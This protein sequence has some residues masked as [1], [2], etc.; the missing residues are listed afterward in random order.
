MFIPKG[1]HKFRKLWK[2]WKEIWS[3]KESLRADILNL[4]CTLES[5][6]ERLKLFLLRPHS[7]PIR[8]EWGKGWVDISAF[9]SFLSS[10]WFQCVAKSESYWITERAI[11][12]F[13]ELTFRWWSNCNKIYVFTKLQS[14]VYL[15]SHFSWEIAYSLLGSSLFEDPDT[16]I[17]YIGF[18]MKLDCCFPCKQKQQLW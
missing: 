14:Q 6:R 7:R 9:F 12:N 16:G 13:K 18:Q 2:Q 1:F 15:E 3:F 5:C 17:W 4:V 8:L 10:S 11:L